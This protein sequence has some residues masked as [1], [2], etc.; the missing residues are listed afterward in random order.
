MGDI[1]QLENRIINQCK[2]DDTSTARDIYL[3]VI[4]EYKKHL[5][6]KKT[7]HKEALIAITDKYIKLNNLNYIK[8]TH[9]PKHQNAFYPLAQDKT[10]HITSYDVAFYN[11]RP[12][13]EIKAHHQCKNIKNWAEIYKYTKENIE[14]IKR[15][16]NSNNEENIK[17]LAHLFDCTITNA[18]K[19]ECNSV[20]Y[21][22]CEV[23]GDSML[24]GN[25]QIDEKKNKIGNAG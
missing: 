6:T 11:P 25:M 15:L 8:R 14:E 9:A 13:V 3:A 18:Q 5:H 12:G 4:A 2:N 19:T 1:K 23:F 16:S 20:F 10:A 7:L 22:R 24:I 21:L 17:H